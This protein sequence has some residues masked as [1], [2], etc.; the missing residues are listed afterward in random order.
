MHLPSCSDYSRQTRETVL[1]L[2]SLPS[3]LT[4]H[5]PSPQSKRSQVS[6]EKTVDKVP[7]TLGE[8][9]FLL[10]NI[11]LYVLLSNVHSINTMPELFQ[12]LL[13][14]CLYDSLLIL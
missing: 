13:Q 8:S 7:C 6:H 4:F 10:T 2:P 12:N 3:Q 5:S 9:G 1:P 14:N 11:Q